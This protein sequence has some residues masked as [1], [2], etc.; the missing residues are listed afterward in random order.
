M[1]NLIGFKSFFSKIKLILHNQLNQLYCIKAI[2]YAQSQ[3]NIM[4]LKIYE[5]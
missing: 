5:Y 2:Y 4:S 1:S 3:Y